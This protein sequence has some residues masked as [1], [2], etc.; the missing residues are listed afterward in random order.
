MIIGSPFHTHN[1][2]QAIQPVEPPAKPQEKPANNVSDPLQQN[3]QSQSKNN[4][5]LDSLGQGRLT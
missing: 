2:N 5:S 4:S 3:A 1:I